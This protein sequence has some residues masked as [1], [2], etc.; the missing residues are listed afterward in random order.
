MMCEEHVR[1]HG[2]AAEA[3]Y[4][5]GVMAEA[6]ESKGDGL[7]KQPDSP[8]PTAIEYY[9]KALY[10]E[11][12]HYEALLHLALLLEKNGDAASREAARQYK[13]RAERV[14]SRNGGVTGS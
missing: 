1:R 13:R 4:L 7:A 14:Q 12:N 9:R 10:L 2:P 3:Y 5:L 8:T 6:L 11:P